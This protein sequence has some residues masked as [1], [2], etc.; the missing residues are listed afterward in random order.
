MVTITYH[1]QLSKFMKCI[2]FDP[3]IT[4]IINTT[5]LEVHPVKC[6]IFD[7]RISDI[8]NTTSLDV[9]PM[10]CLIFHPA[11]LKATPESVPH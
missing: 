4:D 10:K 11:D 3:R 7:P 1:I 9:H 8:I 2:N 6:L 5:S